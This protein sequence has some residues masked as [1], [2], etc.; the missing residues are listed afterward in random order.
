[1]PPNNWSY[2]VEHPRAPFTVLRVIALR[3]RALHLE[4]ETPAG[5][6]QA[7]ISK[8]HMTLYVYHKDGG[9]VREAWIEEWLA[10]KVGIMESDECGMMNDE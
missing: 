4:I 8:R 1:M 10:R 7:W 3:K 9:I 5:P 6:K 2:R